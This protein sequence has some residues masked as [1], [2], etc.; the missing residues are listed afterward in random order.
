MT[1]WASFH[2]DV[3]RPNSSLVDE[4]TSGDDKRLP[5]PGTQ[6]LQWGEGS[7]S[8]EVVWLEQCIEVSFFS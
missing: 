8:T 2:V 5:P 7:N 1:L 3:I 6:A 4:V